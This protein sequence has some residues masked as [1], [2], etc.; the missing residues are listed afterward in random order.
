MPNFYTENEDIVW[1]LH[2]MDLSE[3]IRLTEHD[4]AD[5]GQYPY[6]V[7][8]EADALDSYG[9][10]LELVGDL[11]GNVLAPRATDVDRVS[12]RLEDGV[13]HYAPG[14]VEALEAFSR[15]DVMG[16]TLPRRYGGLNMPVTLYCMAIDMV[17]RAD[18]AFMTLFGLQDIAETINSFA[19]E[20]QKQRYLPRFSS[21]QATGAMV[22][23]E[24]D[25][26]SDLQ[27]A[28][29]RAYQDETGQ[30][31][32]LGVKRF[33]TNGC[34]DVL[35]V[36][37]RSEEGTR[38]ARGLSMFIC[39]KGP[40]VVIQRL[41]DKLGIH[42]SPTCQMFFKDAPAELVGQRRRGLITYVSALMNGARVA[43]AA[44][45]VGL[46]EAA[47]RAALAYAVERRQ[48]GKA[49]FDIPAVS[50]M[51]VDMK[52]ATE[53]SRSL[54][55]EC[56]RAVDMEHGLQ[57]MLDGMDRKHPDF[58]ATRARHATYR[59]LATVL[60]PMAKYYCCNTCMDVTYNNIQVHGGSGFMRDYEAERY[61]RDARITTIYEGTSELQ[62]VAILA[63]LHGGVLADYLDDRDR[64]DY[65][66]GVADLH[67]VAQG[68]R[69]HLDS[70]LAHCRDRGD[71]AYT[72]SMARHLSDL[73]CDT[74]ISYLLLDEAQR[75]ERKLAAAR[76][77]IR[78]AAIRAAGAAAEVEADDDTATRDY[79][80]L[81]Q[82]D[83][84]RA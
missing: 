54:L 19:D 4:F 12:V 71:A 51:L 36:M 46:S 83:V 47:Y 63:G 79:R 25:A 64:R 27:A 77:F 80:A 73:A 52:V 23:T 59:K 9:R 44:Q 82:D 37:A 14:T 2:H 32:L 7:A 34:G 17:S 58:K 3:V 81:L 57:A 48:F 11:A 70:S 41:E 22:L 10:V 15:A 84:P 38:D 55:Y 56:G 60:T 29:L 61:W 20:D 5:A 68:T 53:T 74:V 45:G 42:G 43:I 50:A 24:P 75:S 69:A 33:I 18:A 76:R 78:Q 30:W 8:D 13:V 62:A 40:D 21:G 67:K 39:D 65:G 49:I 26:G 1:H 16:L 66:S 6:A 72:D 35:L 28:R 31:R